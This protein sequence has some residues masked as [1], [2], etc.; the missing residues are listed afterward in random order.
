MR[1]AVGGKPGILANFMKTEYY[2]GRGYL[3]VDIDISTSGLA[4]RVRGSKARQWGWSW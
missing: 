3:E 2:A 4:K 1:K